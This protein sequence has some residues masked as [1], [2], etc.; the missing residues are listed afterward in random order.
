VETIREA[1]TALPIA[2]LKPLGIA[3]PAQDIAVGPKT[4]WDSLVLI[5]RKC[6][7]HPSRGWGVFEAAA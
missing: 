4:R 3:K 5:E 6:S 2:V 7:K 1:V